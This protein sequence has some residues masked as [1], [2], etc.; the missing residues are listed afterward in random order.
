MPCL[1]R[2]PAA[3]RHALEHAEDVHGVEAADHAD[4]VLAVAREDVVLRAGRA[5]GAD[6]GGLL[7]VARHPEGEL[8]LTLQIGGIPIESAHDHHVAVELPEVGVAEALEV[9]EE[10]GGC[11]VRR[12]LTVGGEHL[13]PGHALLV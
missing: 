2:I 4:D 6:L 5:A 9:G 8:A 10:L 3:H 7:A 13:H 12:E 1:G 11:L